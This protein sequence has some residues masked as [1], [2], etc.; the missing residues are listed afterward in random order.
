MHWRIILPLSFALGFAMG[1][2]SVMGWTGK[3]GS[4]G[5]R[6]EPILWIFI[7]FIC[8]IVIIA[9]IRRRRFLH[10]LLI[11][12]VLALYNSI[13]QSVFN[14]MYF[15]NNAD[16]REQFQQTASIPP[17]VLVLITGPIIGLIY[18]TLLGGLA[19]LLGAILQSRQS[20]M[21]HSKE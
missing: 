9:R 6:L 17:R 7:A 8:A 4:T 11:G 2:A 18:G 19:L 14:E 10:G 20:T 16:I 5:I 3:I 12:I 1:G 21:P 13:C 15:A